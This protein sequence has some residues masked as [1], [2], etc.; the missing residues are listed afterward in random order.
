MSLS[1]V[2]QI[3]HFRIE[4]IHQKSQKAF[5]IVEAMARVLYELC[6]L[7]DLLLIFNILLT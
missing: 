6:R 7:R 4:A 3:M 2:V 5:P 1:Y